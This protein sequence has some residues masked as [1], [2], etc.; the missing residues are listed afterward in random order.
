[1]RPRKGP[2][3]LCLSPRILLHIR[4]GIWLSV[5]L[6]NVE[7][8]RVEIAPIVPHKR[9]IGT[10][11]VAAARRNNSCSVEEAS[12]SK[13]GASGETKPGID[14]IVID[15]FD[16]VGSIGSDIHTLNVTKN[17]N[18]LPGM[19]AV[20]NVP[21]GSFTELLQSVVPENRQPTLVWCCITMHHPWE[22]ASLPRIGT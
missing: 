15:Q 12:N 14:L 7:L 2:P 11:R 9:R 21:T 22:L 10:N 18:E 6:G 17:T 4:I 8:S 1:M 3:A 5:E 20:L 13:G 16:L 19:L